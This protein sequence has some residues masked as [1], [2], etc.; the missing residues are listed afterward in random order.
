MCIKAR[1][2]WYSFND[3]SW[4]T[5]A[6]LNRFDSTDLWDILLITEQYKLCPILS[7]SIHIFWAYIFIWEYTNNSFQDSREICFDIT[8]QSGN[9]VFHRSNCY[10]RVPKNQTKWIIAELIVLTCKS[11]SFDSVLIC[12]S[13]S[14][15]VIMLLILLFWPEN[16]LQSKYS[17]KRKQCQTKSITL[18]VNYCY[19]TWP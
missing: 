8:L 15:S 10:L 18:L 19:T 9:L 5:F 17:N 1:C 14:Y 13:E 7:T 12:I 4:S 6:F 3:H 11:Q 2:W 16:R